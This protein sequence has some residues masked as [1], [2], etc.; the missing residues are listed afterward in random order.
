MSRHHQE[1]TKRGRDHLTIVRRDPETDPLAL[2][3]RLLRLAS[4]LFVT[5]MV[6]GMWGVVV[7]AAVLLWG[8]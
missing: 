5:A 3:H 4:W 7:A 6:A 2:K 1:I 8:I